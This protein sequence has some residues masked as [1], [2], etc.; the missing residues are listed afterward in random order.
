MMIG[1]ERNVPSLHR[2]ALAGAIVFLLSL[3]ACAGPT[4]PSHTDPPPGSDCVLVNGQW[5]CP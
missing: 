5:V 1:T 4:E 3:G 2:L